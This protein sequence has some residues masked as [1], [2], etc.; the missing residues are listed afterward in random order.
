MH[1]KRFTETKRRRSIGQQL[2]TKSARGPGDKP[3]VNRSSTGRC[4]SCLVYLAF[5]LFMPTEGRLGR[6]SSVPWMAR[7]TVFFLSRRPGAFLGPFTRRHPIPI[8]RAP[9]RRA[10]PR[11]RRPPRCLR[12]PAP[13]P[14]GMSEFWIRQVTF[15]NRIYVFVHDND[16]LNI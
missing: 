11:P 14:R 12:R 2:G 7:L 15:L 4:V 8:H 16:V 6:L 3:L 13:S 10:P 1:K 9:P 5:P